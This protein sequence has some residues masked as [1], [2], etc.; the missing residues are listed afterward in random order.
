MSQY[1]LLKKLTVQ[2]ANAIAGLTYGFPAITNFLGFAHA[3]SRKLPKE[4]G[5][6]LGGVAVISHKNSV[7]ARQPKGWGDYVFAL[8]RNPLTH[9]GKTAPINEEGRMNMQISLLIEVSGLQAGNLSARDELLLQVEK[10]VPN[11]RLAGGQITQYERPDVVDSEDTTYTLRRLMPGF[12]LIDR[13]EYLADHYKTLLQ[14]DSNASLFDAW[15]DF[16][17]L[18]FKAEA[19]ENES[20]HAADSTDASALKAQ[21]HYLKKPKAGYLVPINSGYCAISPVYDAGKV[22][23]VRDQSTPVVFA[24]SAYSIGEWKS[25]HA[26]KIEN[27]V[28]RY[29]QQNSWYLAKTQP[30]EPELIEPDDLDKESSEEEMPY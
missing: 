25:V 9:Q 22:A 3:I 24:E 28:W 11:L 18:K 23:N 17:Q 7:H 5:I 15:C 8:S 2:N 4:M 13:S 10:I 29:E 27:A 12:A 14:Q 26:L 1:L 30:F 6:K 19:P 21:W 20:E 16:A